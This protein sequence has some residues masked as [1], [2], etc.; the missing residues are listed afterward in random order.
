[1]SSV[2][3]AVEIRRRVFAV[4]AVTVMMVAALPLV[5]GDMQPLVAQDTG[6][7]TV[8]YHS[9]AGDNGV[10]VNYYGA[11]V[12]EYNPEYWEDVDRGLS[13]WTPPTIT[14]KYSIDADITWYFTALG[15][16]SV[17]IVGSGSM[18]SVSVESIDVINKVIDGLG[19]IQV[20]GNNGLNLY[21]PGNNDS[22]TIRINL[23]Y[24]G[25][26]V[27]GGW[28]GG[29]VDPGD[30]VSDGTSLTANWVAP[31]LHLVSSSESFHFNSDNT[32]FT[33]SDTLD[34][35]SEKA[36]V[37]ETPEGGRGASQ[38]YTTIYRME[39]GDVLNGTLPTGTYRSA[40]FVNGQTD[41]AAISYN[42]GTYLGGPVIID[43]VSLTG[44][45]RGSTTTQTESTGLYANGKLL[46]LGTGMVCPDGSA[47]DDYV[48][49]YGGWRT[50]GSSSST[51]VRVFSGTYS[52]IIGG[53]GD[54]SYTDIQSTNVTIAGNASVLESVIGGSINGYVGTTNVLVA[55]GRVDSYGYH[56]DVI[57]PGFSTVIGGGRYGDVGTSNVEVSGTAKVFA[58]QG[59]GRTAD[60]HTDVTNVTISGKAEIIEMVCGSV[61]DGRDK[62]TGEVPVGQSNVTV[63]D[64]ATVKS[65]YGG[66]WDIWQDPEYISTGTAT[67]NIEGG[68]IG[69]I[70]GGG[71]RG[72][73]GV[74]GQDTVK[75]TITG[76]DIGSVY[77]GGRGGEDPI[78]RKTPDNPETTG[79][80]Y[81]NNSGKAY[82]YGNVIIDVSGQATQI[83]T[84][85]GGG[86][87]IT[88]SDVKPT[89]EDVAMVN[90]NV[91]MTVGSGV[92]VGD[93]Y[94]GGYG[95]ANHAAMAKVVGD[96]KIDASGTV[97]GSVYGGGNYGAVG[98]DVSIS[99]Y[100]SVSGSVHGGGNQGDVAGSATVTAE[101]GSNVG[102]V[103]GGGYSGTVG[104]T[105]VKVSGTAG[106]VYGGGEN[107]KVTG[108]TD[109]TVDST[110]TVTGNL[111]GG[112][113]GAEAIVS[114][115]SIVVLG[116]A[117]GA[118]YG[119]GNL[120]S[121]SGN[122]T[123]SMT[124]A[125]VG[126]VYGGGS[127]EGGT[128]GAA[129]VSG[130]V[131]ITLIDTTVAGSLYGGGHG[132]D[133]SVLDYETIAVVEGDVSVSVTGGSVGGDLYGGGEYGLLA[134][135][136]PAT[137]RITLKDASV[138]GSVYSGGMGEEG[139]M[140]TGLSD[141]FLTIDGGSYGG[142]I[143]GGSRFG[144]DNLESVDSAPTGRGSFIYILSGDI[145]GGSSG[146]VY[147]GGY[148]GYS[149]MDSHVY[150]G[151]SA[152]GST[153]G[154]SGT[155]K[156]RSVYG[157]SSVGA[158][159]EGMLTAKL[160][161]GDAEV[162]I[163]GTSVTLTGD[164]FGAGD[165]C[166]IDGTAEVRFEGFSQAGTMLSVQKADLLVL[167]DSKVHLRGNIDGSSTTGSPMFS[168]NLIGQLELVSVDE[169][170]EIVLDSAASQISGLSSTYSSI[171]AD[172]SGYN[173]L[174][175]NNGMVFSILG[176]GNAGGD[177][178]TVEGMTLIKSDSN[179]YFGALVMADR[180][181]LLNDPTFWCATGDGYQQLEYDDYDYGT[182]G[183]RAWHLQGAYKVEQTVVFEDKTGTGETMEKDLL[184]TLPKVSNLSSIVYAGHYVTPSSPGSMQL[185][186]TPEDPGRDLSVVFGHGVGSGLTLFGETLDNGSYA[187]LNLA[188][189][190]GNVP[191][192]EYSSGA[193][194]NMSLS[195]IG[196]YNS[197]GYI[198][199]VIV[200]FA[201]VSGGIV[202][203]ILDVEVKVYLRTSVIPESGLE[204]GVV[205]RGEDTY[206]GTVDIYLPAL[207]GNATGVYT[208]ESVMS[209][210]TL[211][212]LTVPTNLNRD[213]WIQ[214]EYRDAPLILKDGEGG[215]TLGTGG[216]FSPVLRVT[217]T[218]SDINDDETFDP[219]T[220]T[221]T[222]TPET[223]SGGA[224]DIVLTVTPQMAS[225]N[226]VT[227]Y[228]K[229]LDLSAEGSWSEYKKMFSIGI[230]FGDS[231]DQY[232]VVVN[233]SRW[234]TD[235]DAPAFI[236]SIEDSLMKNE[237][238]TVTIS[239][240]PK[241]LEADAS[242]FGGEVLAVRTLLEAIID[243]KPVTTYEDNNETSLTFDYGEEE[244]G[245]Y[246]S[247]DGH[248][249]FDFGSEIA[250]AE[251]GVYSGYSIA[252]YVKVKNPG[253]GGDVNQSV[254][255]P[256]APGSVLDLYGRIGVTP[257]YE[258]TEWYY[259]ESADTATK[260]QPTIDSDGNIT[261]VNL[262]TYSTTTIYVV[263]EKVDYSL[264][265]VFDDG[266][267]TP[268]TYEYTVSGNSIDDG[269]RVGDSIE[270]TVSDLGTMHISGA[271]GNNNTWNTF[272][273]GTD[274]VSFTAPAMD[275][276][277]TIHL[278]SNYTATVTL[279]QNGITDDN[280]LFGFQSVGETDL[281]A[282]G[283][284]KSMTIVSTT[285]TDGSTKY[286]TIYAPTY[287]GRKVVLSLYGS[288]GMLVGKEYAES[289]SFP[290]SD[291]GADASYTLYVNV[292]W[293]VTLGT[294]YTATVDDSELST[295]GTVRTGDEIKLTLAEGYAFGTE[296]SARGAF[297]TG[298]GAGYRIYTVNTGDGNRTDV[299]FG[300]AEYAMIQVTVKVVFRVDGSQATSEPSG[301]VSVNGDILSEGVWDSG[302]ITYKFNALKQTY[303]FTAEF[304]GYDD[305]SV[306]Q[307][308]G[309][310]TT[311]IIE[312][313]A[314]SH[315]VIF[316]YSGVTLGTYTW[317]VGDTKTVSQMYTGGGYVA[318]TDGKEL[319]HGDE[320]LDLDMFTYRMLT[321]EGLPVI[322]DVESKWEVM[323]VLAHEGQLA[324]GLVINVGEGYEDPEASFNTESVEIDG[325]YLTLKISG[326]TG[327]FHVV[328][329]GPE[330]NLMLI[331]TVAVSVGDAGGT[332]PF[333]KI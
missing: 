192:S 291:L 180:R 52:N 232:Y 288:D 48:E 249:P 99:L 70:Y 72:P 184:F 110:G 187:G 231:V 244:P 312:L 282:G 284:L 65:V 106:T 287:E 189:Q 10:T 157:G 167:E 294:G 158:S 258:I 274:L 34:F 143:Y 169:V 205:M 276:V 45:D 247:P 198:G 176:E 309:E 29:D 80:G 246:D 4:F 18:G 333:L 293:E 124:S 240:D 150:I 155:V 31:D 46:I 56:G 259:G 159:D 89:V 250:N 202:F 166:D 325:D 278:S 76:G 60:S 200:H 57:Y 50:G 6:L 96:I 208:V 138:G 171:P 286:I 130:D 316:T 121:V 119:G 256:G 227:F 211:E 254:L 133:R 315:S 151:E 195:V 214:T 17:Q 310:D 131:V 74:S 108:S 33:V 39:S 134:G 64:A 168:L 215:M 23:T 8:T 86:M 161:I 188:E 277:V 102:D 327:S 304:A 297:M 49:V 318:W 295:G 237:D 125:A 235:G 109:V 26:A 68:T 182:L 330:T 75:I 179:D 100:G 16:R 152:E 298:S 257:G 308:I 251:V 234:A 236:D 201:E 136:T 141:R 107:G 323:A 225:V 223:G 320:T 19:H 42:G 25:P 32:K 126:A 24:N 118:V 13:N 279:P 209:E 88:D 222:V 292:Q 183:V 83:D 228:D 280:V 268:E 242:K 93:I 207:S 37:T 104:S 61:T 271:T 175:I 140:A 66:G 303:T 101:G 44:P 241:T 218:T 40:S 224:R 146:N 317:Y 253:C 41:V 82:V 148:R 154:T 191:S 269:F 63:R 163:G 47:S 226:T 21:D 123:V 58:V 260:I 290:I 243:A 27:F 162:R 230:L 262:T 252:L 135:S 43:N 98:G 9:T 210:G 22:A 92:T 79:S 181:T 160:L 301:T 85:Y 71:F 11:A 275:L 285:S 38:M 164:V 283:G 186:S 281:A 84:I 87:G 300:D 55:G 267:E 30:P 296:F 153:G 170:S 105:I 178:G 145:A 2:P 263:L 311:V 213:G 53:S 307:Y 120:G 5:I 111:Y 196:G 67:V 51:D 62:D 103:Y 129:R 314:I 220:I 328:L 73:I 302:I 116:K 219:F 127:G 132:V 248:T 265:V 299:E 94:G 28:N 289:V 217:Y 321:L 173:V 156:V 139:R 97:T 239:T 114:D 326:G 331:V 229:V 174:T 206:T 212:V 194:L 329:H 90:G 238:G 113:K 266:N 255:F 115:V 112:G 95:S 142:S 245:W 128:A 12:A 305:G 272:I 165:F 59:G 306:T 14:A 172:A 322:E 78:E 54:Q 36:T 91:R 117:T 149:A 264:K 122:V 190:S 81:T 35:N 185:V 20:E 177:L 77:G 193:G 69:S 204:G 319:L 144:N 203:N 313:D 3:A 147:G 15:G 197:T 221:V 270:I 261:S 1:M 7:K 199:S 233:K 137:L 216:V 332:G 324:E 273:V